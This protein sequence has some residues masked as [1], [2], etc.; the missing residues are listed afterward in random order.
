MSIK[1][2]TAELTG[3]VKGQKVHNFLGATKIKD[4]MN[5]IEVETVYN[6]GSSYLKSI[7][8]VLW[9]SNEQRKDDI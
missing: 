5:K 4:H 3:V 8:N 9:K 2:P 7:S 1:D 6:P